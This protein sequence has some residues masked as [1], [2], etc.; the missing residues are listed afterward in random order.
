MKKHKYKF[1]YSFLRKFAPLTLKIFIKKINNFENL[2][3]K[4]PYIIAS[5]HISYLDPLILAA[6]YQFHFNERLYFLG[7]K[8]LFRKLHSR[9]FHETVSTIP[10][11]KADKGKTAFKIAE[12]YLQNNEI[13]GIFPEGRISTTGRLLEGKTGI[14]RL[15]LSAKV[16]VLPIAIKGTSKLMPVGRFIPKFRKKVIINVGKL[17]YFN[18]YYDKKINKTILRSITNKIM[19]N[20]YS[21]KNL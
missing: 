13:V 6:I 10:L 3:S 19:K 7:K 20:I 21:L 11:D 1:L 12:K 16:P 17:I 9:I 15:C 14:A 18:E 8:E 5:N 4:K 2:N